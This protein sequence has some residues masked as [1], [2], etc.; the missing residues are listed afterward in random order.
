MMTK[1]HHDS[2]KDSLRKK[3]RISNK[4]SLLIKNNKHTACNHHKL[5]NFLQQLKLNS[6]YEQ[7]KKIFK[8]QK[9][10][11]TTNSIT[12]IINNVSCTNQKK[13]VVFSNH[14]VL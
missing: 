14:S 4:F 8:K 10:E 11:K 9:N 3:K 1:E 12:K 2:H 5:F 13:D 7:K 6:V